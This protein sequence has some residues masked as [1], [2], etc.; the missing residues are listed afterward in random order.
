MAFEQIGFEQGLQTGFSS[1]W[2]GLGG[3]SGGL[4]GAQPDGHGTNFFII[5]SGKRVT[6]IYGTD[7]IKSGNVELLMRIVSG[8]GDNYKTIL[9]QH[10]ITSSQEPT[11]TLP[12]N[13]RDL[14]FDPYLVGDGYKAVWV[15]WQGI[16]PGSYTGSGRGFELQLNFILE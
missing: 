4:A 6:G 2:E 15:E 7:T 13:I 1:S 5:P 11:H 14:P 3:A 9:Q 12:I 10:H 16:N 8:M